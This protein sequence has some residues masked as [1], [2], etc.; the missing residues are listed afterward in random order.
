MADH[1]ELLRVWW[2]CAYPLGLGIFSANLP[3]SLTY[4]VL[5][6]RGCSPWRPA[7]DIGT[8]HRESILVK[9]G[10]PIVHLNEYFF[11]G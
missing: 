8:A 6:T 10:K 2:E 4:I 7:A 3:T 5:L 1:Y 9:N 11:D